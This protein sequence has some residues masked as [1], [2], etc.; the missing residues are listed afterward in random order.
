MSTRRYASRVS[1]HQFAAGDLT[2]NVASSNPVEVCGI[3]LTNPT[4][5]A[6][7]FSINDSDG[8]LVLTV[9]VATLGHEWIEVPAL[10][11]NGLQIVS[12]TAVV[13]AVVFH[14]SPGN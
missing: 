9:N 7:V 12:D 1:S 10:W 2:F 5:G 11:D 13:S 14:N 4:G 3:H 8:T 6:A